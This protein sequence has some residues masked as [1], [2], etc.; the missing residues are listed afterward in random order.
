MTGIDIILGA[1]IYARGGWSSAW[2]FA[3]TFIG[4]DIAHAMFG[5]QVF[6]Q[7]GQWTAHFLG[8]Q[9]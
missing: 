1:W 2:I 6:E 9:K 5:S 7:A 4:L 3:A 8:W